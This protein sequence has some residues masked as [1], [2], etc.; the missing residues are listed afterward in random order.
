MTRS[1]R[2]PCPGLSRPDWV[3]LSE[4]VKLDCS[5]SQRIEMGLDSW[6]VVHSSS[7]FFFWGGSAALM[8]A[9]LPKI[10][11]CPLSIAGSLINRSPFFFLSFPPPPL[12]P[13]AHPP[14]SPCVYFDP[15][16]SVIGFCV[17]I[18]WRFIVP[19]TSQG[20]LRAFHEFKPYT[21]SIANTSEHLTYIY[22]TRNLTYIFF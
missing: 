22:T 10:W 9:I 15:L 6:F 19:P 4:R 7:C 18:Y 21:S 3:M 2:H 11:L 16:S 8:K 12:P 17:C 14:S 1:A 5:G 13:P 20:H